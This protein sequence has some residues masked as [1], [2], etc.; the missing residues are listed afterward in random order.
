MTWRICGLIEGAWMKTPNLSR[1]AFIIFVMLV[2]AG[3]TSHAHPMWGIAVDIRGQ[4]Y[5]TDLTSVWRIDVDGRL[6]VFRPKGD[7][8]VHE[9]SLDSEGNLLGAE[10]TYD[11]ATKKFFSAIW[12]MTPAG[13]SSYL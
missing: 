12:K 4:V 10:N 6:S 5:F 13:Q 8:H 3:V 1:L 2:A 9:I 11:P 7:G